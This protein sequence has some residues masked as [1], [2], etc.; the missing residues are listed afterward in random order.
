MNW[1]NP[2][3]P[4]DTELRIHFNKSNPEHTVVKTDSKG[5]VLHLFGD[6]IS[7]YKKA[8]P[9]NVDTRPPT[10]GNI[11]TIGIYFYNDDRPIE[12]RSDVGNSL[13]TA[14]YILQTL[15]LLFDETIV[16]QRL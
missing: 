16:A 3:E 5:G 4:A 7:Q 1:K 2:P 11:Y 14:K 6:W 15:N 9:E 8:D 12:V 10:V 13:I